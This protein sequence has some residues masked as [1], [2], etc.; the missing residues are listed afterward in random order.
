MSFTH[1]CWFSRTRNNNPKASALPKASDLNNLAAWAEHLKATEFVPVLWVNDEVEC[2]LLSAQNNHTLIPAAGVL[3]ATPATWHKNIQHL[4]GRV[5]HNNVSLWQTRAPNNRY[6][7]YSKK[8]G[9]LVVNV[10]GFFDNAAR[11]N[12][13][14]KALKNLFQ[15]L[16]IEQLFYHLKNYLVDFLICY[17]KGFYFDL[18]FSPKTNTAFFKSMRSVN[19]ALLVYASSHELLKLG[20]IFNVLKHDPQYPDAISLDVSMKV[21]VGAE[22]DLVKPFARDV[23]STVIPIDWVT[24]LKQKTARMKI[25]ST[26][27]M[28]AAIQRQ[29][30]SKLRRYTQRDPVDLQR[31]LRLDSLYLNKRNIVREIVFDNK[32]FLAYAMLCDS[33]LVDQ[34]KSMHRFSQTQGIHNWLKKVYQPFYEKYF[35]DK[36]SQMHPLLPS[37]VFNTGF[38]SIQERVEAAEILS[39]HKL[40]QHVK[41]WLATK[42]AERVKLLSVPKPTSSCAAGSAQ[43]ITSG[44]G[45]SPPRPASNRPPSPRGVIGQLM[46]EAVPTARGVGSRSA[47]PTPRNVTGSSTRRQADDNPYDDPNFW[48]KIVGK[49]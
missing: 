46:P 16:V 4:L 30:L 14:F 10:E 18:D 15:L 33:M 1:Y 40:Q 23:F 19:T 7:S 11:V 6:H 26:K 13:N 36:F 43:A 49:M 45:A 48:A 29:P 39:E 9:V 3:A 5:G 38:Y 31:Q 8:M 47:I 21:N 42:R 17:L 20:K 37:R 12:P 34:A 25:A 44:P 22:C 24:D 41:S 2:E 27:T 32:I 28:K 35:F